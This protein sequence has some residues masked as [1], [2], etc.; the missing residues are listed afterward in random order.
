MKLIEITQENWLSMSNEEKGN[1][2][3]MIQGVPRNMTVVARR[4]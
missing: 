3:I 1:A 4:L 2:Q